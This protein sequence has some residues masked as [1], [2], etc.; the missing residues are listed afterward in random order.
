M[1]VDCCIISLI[2]SCRRVVAPAG[3][4]IA[5]LASK[6]GSVLIRGTVF[7]KSSSDAVH[8]VLKDKDLASGGYAKV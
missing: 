7:L 5:R 1:L 8:Y 6:R 3:G 2:L 4:R